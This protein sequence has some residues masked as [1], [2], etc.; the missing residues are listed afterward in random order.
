LAL[1][2]GTLTIHL[3]TSIVY[4]SKVASMEFKSIAQRAGKW[5]VV[6]ALLGF[7]FAMAQSEPT[8]GEVYA[9]AQSGQLDKAQT[10]IQ[11]VLVSHPNSGK[12][13]FVRAELYSRQGDL[14]RARDELATAEKLAPG[15]PFAKSDAVQA[16]RAQLSTR[17]RAQT[18]TAPVL[19][20]AAPAVPSSTFSW[21]LPLL[22]AGGII[23][24]G[25]LA[26]RKRAPEPF[27]Q[28]AAY[29][30]PSGL[31]GPQSFGLAG[32]GAGPSMQPA[33][34]QPTSPQQASSGIGGQIMGGLATGLAVGAGVMAAQAIGR[35]LMGHTNEPTNQRDNFSEV[36]QPPINRNV[37]M[38]GQDFGV[39]DANSWDDGG[40]I[41]VGGGGDWDN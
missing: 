23:F 20:R 18:T 15:L 32:N 4:I 5:V 1:V 27:I 6:A 9:A 33:Y 16:L 22:L 17:P 8:L 19:S 14:G 36:D 39:N 25:Y 7:G 34:P 21:G 12:A 11:Q 40:A 24:L 37:N 2:F 3:A 30:P 35:N 38:G 28:P 13:H 10:L 41:D 29:A 26:F 31:N